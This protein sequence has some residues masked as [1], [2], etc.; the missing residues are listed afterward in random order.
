VADYNSVTLD[1]AMNTSKRQLFWEEENALVV[2]VQSCCKVL[3]NILTN[4]FFKMNTSKN[5]TIVIVTKSCQTNCNCSIRGYKHLLSCKAS[6][7]F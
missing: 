4:K 6:G 7:D 1:G 5:V 2:S 3:S